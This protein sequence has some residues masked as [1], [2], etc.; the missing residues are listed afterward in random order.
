M[1]GRRCGVL[2]KLQDW[3]YCAIYQAV[4][5]LAH[6]PPGADVYLS[7]PYKFYQFFRMPNVL[8]LMEIFLLKAFKL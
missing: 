2:V 6:L 5:Y 4:P 1:N 8:P 3:T 7:A